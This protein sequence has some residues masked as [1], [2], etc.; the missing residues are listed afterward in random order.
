MVGGFLTGV[1]VGEVVVL[2][3]MRQCLSLEDG[4]VEAAAA[5]SSQ[6][7]NLSSKMRRQ[8]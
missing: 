8:S 6:T 3:Q 7:S 4:R 5:T 1:D 2:K